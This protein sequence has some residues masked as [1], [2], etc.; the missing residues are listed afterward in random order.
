MRC[1]IKTR[2]LGHSVI[3]LVTAIA[4][5][6]CPSIAIADTT[7]PCEEISPAS[8]SNTIGTCQN[9]ACPGQLI[10][11]HAQHACAG[12]N[13]ADCTNSPFPLMTIVSAKQKSLGFAT[14][15]LCI[16]PAGSAC[17]AI[18][19][20]AAG[21]CLIPVA[22]WGCVLAWAGTSG[23]CFGLSYVPDPCCWIDC[24]IDMTTLFDVPGGTDCE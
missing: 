24:V 12:E 6:L 13:E 4:M 9:G 17:V 11:V 20:G 8:E 5:L 15:L 1:V 2:G 22:W 18:A 19:A 10:V 23:A 3:A 14:F 7:G 21:L 16:A